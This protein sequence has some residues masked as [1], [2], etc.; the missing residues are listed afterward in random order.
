MV[1]ST[2]TLNPD[3]R[4]IEFLK[5]S[6]KPNTKKKFTLNTLSLA[7]DWELRADLGTRPR[8]QDHIVQTPRYSVLLK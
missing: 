2:N 1:I 6:D 4:S 5:V 7:T 3:K 8:F